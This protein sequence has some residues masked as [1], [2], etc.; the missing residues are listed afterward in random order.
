[1]VVLLVFC[2]VHEYFIQNVLSTNGFD[3]EEVTGKGFGAA[4]SEC[5]KNKKFHD[6]FL[7][8]PATGRMAV[9]EKI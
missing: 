8:A 9:H 4:W 7:A 5:Q 6:I 3:D 1:M 2:T